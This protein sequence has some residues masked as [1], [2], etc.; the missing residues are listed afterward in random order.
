VKKILKK[1]MCIIRN[2]MH[3]TK[4]YST[5]ADLKAKYGKYVMISENTY[6]SKNTEIGDYSYVN[7]NSSIE[8]ATIGKY[9]SISSGV[10]ISPY[11]HKRE[12]IS[13]SPYNRY[14]NSETKRV[15]IGHDVLISLN[16]IILEGVQIGNGAIIGA[17]AIVTRDVNP[18]EVVGGV[19]AK[20]IRYRFSKEK[21]EYLQNLKWWDKEPL[22]IKKNKAFFNN[23]SDIFDDKII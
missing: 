1:I 13:T 6:I 11:N 15:N 21:I 22:L 10:Y 17:G 23:E 7:S 19:P 18:Y 20:H 3:K 9:C 4:I 16:V 14:Y 5:K 8:N 2:I 12:Y